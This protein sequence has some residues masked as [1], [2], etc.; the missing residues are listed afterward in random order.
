MMD[1]VYFDKIGSENIH[2]LVNDHIKC[3]M[4]RIT[5]T[6]LKNHEYHHRSKGISDRY[7]HL[8]CP[9]ISGDGIMSI[10]GIE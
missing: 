7:V 8:L 9:D 6:L 5:V 10:N 1:L 2:V 3:D 4:M